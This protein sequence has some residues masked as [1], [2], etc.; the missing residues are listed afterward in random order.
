MAASGSAGLGAALIPT[1]AAE[2]EI[3][4]LLGK[5][6]LDAAFQNRADAADRMFLDG[7]P[8]H[9][10]N[11]DED[12]LPNFIGTFS[13][14]LPH[15][16]IGEVDPVA[17]STFRNALSSGEPSDFELIPLGGARRL[18]N[19][20]A[21][22]AF[23]TE[24][25]D[26][27]QFA[28]PPA[29]AFSSAEEAAEIAENYW[30]ALLRDVPFNDYDRHPLARRAAAELSSLTDFT[31]PRQGG[32][33]TTQTLFRDDLPGSTVGPYISQFL[34]LGT[35]F[36]AE[37]V[38][39]RMRTLLP[40]TDQ[41]TRFDEWLAV[42]NGNVPGRQRFDPVRRYIRNGRDLAEWVHIDVLFQAYFNAAL[43]MLHPPNPQNR[44][45]RGGI[46]CPLNPG[47]PYHFTATQDPFG[48]W[49]PPGIAALLCEIASRALKA[50]WFQKW[51]VHRRLRPEA[52]AGRVHAHLTGLASYPIHPQ[53]LESE[54]VDRVHQR[55]RSFLLPM[56]FPEGSP[57]H[58]AYGAGHATVAGACVTVL[59]ALFDETFVIE[60]PV[61]ADNSGLQLRPLRGVELTV[62]GELNKLASNV[63]TGRNVAGVHWRTDGIESLRL[64]E[65]LAIAV[66]QDYKNLHNE[67]G[68][69]IFTRFDG[70]PI[71][72]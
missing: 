13:K 18:C 25:N 7:I 58:P 30:M 20:Q 1:H 62:G 33:V 51:Y 43:I 69:Y 24:G 6:R 67:G 48:T 28:Q 55:F 47:N 36:G 10:D 19:P 35:P 23:D 21:G 60:R 8:D 12:S 27:H 5:D 2:A 65:A 34:L 72:I 50:V 42:Q 40:N 59:K 14:G 70:T 22:L 32:A 41:M 56:V 57:V 52:F 26:P 68:N 49:G 16:A 46:A 54:V 37:Y 17:F 44:P 15:N 64:G 53:I 3:G 39:R 66:L 11:G 29:P 4:P 38:E 71:T 9:P 63:A 31:G 45:T 61:V